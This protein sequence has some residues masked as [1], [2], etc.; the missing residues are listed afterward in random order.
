MQWTWEHGSPPSLPA[1]WVELEDEELPYPASPAALTLPPAQQPVACCY[2]HNTTNCSHRPCACVCLYIHCIHVQEQYMFRLQKV[3]FVF[4]LFNPC[5]T[6]LLCDLIGRNH[7]KLAYI[8]HDVMSCVA[9]TV[10]KLVASLKKREEIDWWRIRNMCWQSKAFRTGW[11]L[12]YRSGWRIQNMSLESCCRARPG[13]RWSLTK[14]HLLAGT[15]L[16]GASCL[17][18]GLG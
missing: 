5:R 8:R 1:G 12:S 17:C 3:R 11:G 13:W 16:A 9:H 14:E 7:R 4:L 6:C 15:G 18:Q 2:T 10:M